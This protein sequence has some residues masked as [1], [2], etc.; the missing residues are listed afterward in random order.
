MSSLASG[1]SVRLPKRVT[2]LEGE[3]N[4]RSGGKWSRWYSPHENDQK[5]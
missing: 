4:P 3:T 1:F 2:G 5:D